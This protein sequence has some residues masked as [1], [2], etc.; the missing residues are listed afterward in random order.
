MA[1]ETQTDITPVYFTLDKPFLNKKR[2]FQESRGGATLKA[3]VL[4]SILV[5]GYEPSREGTSQLMDDF[6]RAL[7]S[8]SREFDGGAKEVV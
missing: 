7:E 4:P 8:F 5:A 1:I 2:F 3:Y 6:R